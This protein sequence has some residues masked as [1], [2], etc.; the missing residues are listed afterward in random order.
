MNNLNV[1]VKVGEKSSENFL[2]QF[3]ENTSSLKS[4]LY[5]ENKYSTVWT[6]V[7]VEPLHEG[8]TNW[9]NTSLKTSD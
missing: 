4:W 1:K 8:H 7:K 2:D 5:E 3:P 6:L 9:F